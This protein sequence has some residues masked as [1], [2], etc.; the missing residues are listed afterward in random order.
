MESFFSVFFV[1]CKGGCER[2]GAAYA[3]EAT[4]TRPAGIGLPSG[5]TNGLPL[6]HGRIA[7]FMAPILNS[8]LNLSVNA[9]ILQLLMCN[10]LS[11]KGHVVSYGLMQLLSLACYLCRDLH[12]KAFWDDMP[13]HFC[14]THG[15]WRAAAKLRISKSRLP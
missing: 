13:G 12:I 9:R 14:D 10:H 6:R 8:C 3:R 1:Q 11:D 2:V 4:R 7:L 15:K 5:Q